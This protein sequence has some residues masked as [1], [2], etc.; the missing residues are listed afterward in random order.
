MKVRAQGGAAR[1]ILEPASLTVG[2]DHVFDREQLLAAYERAWSREEEPGIRTELERCW[3]T[4]STHV[5]PLSGVVHGV[6]GLVNLILD[7]PVMFPDARMRMTGRADIHHDQTFLTW[8]LT[9][10]TRIRLMGHDYGHS[11]DGV[12]F[13]E[14]APEGPIRRITSFFGVE[15][16]SA[17]SDAGHA[18][19]GNAT[20]G[21]N[22]YGHTAYRVTTGHTVRST[23]DAESPRVLDLEDPVPEPQSR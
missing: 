5:S 15:R 7:F 23:S 12:D 16:A 4:D 13:V 14:F 18:T 8:R 9:S 11:V 6:E 19:T 3:T 20:T 10:T 21:H 1:H 2:G 22:G 17:P